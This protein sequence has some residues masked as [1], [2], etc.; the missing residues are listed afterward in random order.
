MPSLS[1]S[2]ECLPV[3]LV[4]PQF[5]TA[6]AAFVTNYQNARIIVGTGAAKAKTKTPTLPG[7]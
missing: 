2:L 3:N 7:P 1:A 6:N 5:K 4:V